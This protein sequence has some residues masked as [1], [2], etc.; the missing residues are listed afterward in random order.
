[1]FSSP[2]H[3]PLSL[4]HL[5]DRM[6]CMWPSLPFLF[7]SSIPRNTGWKRKWNRAPWHGLFVFPTITVPILS[8]PSL[9]LLLP[10]LAQQN[11]IKTE[12]KNR[13]AIR[14]RGL[15]PSSSFAMVVTPSLSLLLQAPLL[16][17]QLQGAEGGKSLRFKWWVETEP[18]QR[19]L[20]FDFSLS[21]RFSV[22]KL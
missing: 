6:H 2:P 17:Q 12:N 11:R 9:H 4:F 3:L 21:F 18:G 5:I 7:S 1:M 13:A 14:T 19:V 22:F 20:G 8:L 16:M 10:F 15:S